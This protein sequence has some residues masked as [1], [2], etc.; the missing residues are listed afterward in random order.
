[1]LHVA[2]QPPHIAFVNQPWNVFQPP[3]Q[4]GSIAI[5]TDQVSRRLS[6]EYAV[7]VY[8]KNTPHQGA[9]LSAN[10]QIRY[11]FFSL[12]WDL[13]VHR[14]MKK[15]P[16]QR[17]G[18]LP[19][20]ASQSFFLFYALKVALDLRQ[21]KIDLVHI[22]NLSN[23]VPIIRRLNPEIKIVLHMHCE[24]L[25]Q[26]N[27]FHMEKRIRQCNL[28]LGCSQYIASLISLRFR[29]TRIPVK[30]IANGVAP[31]VFKPKAGAAR[32]KP[33]KPARVL[34]VGRISPEKGLHLLIEAFKRIAPRH[35]DL[36]LQIVGPH[37]PTPPQY[38]VNL[39]AETNVADLHSF[40]HGNYLTY[41]Q[42]NI[43]GMLASR[44]EFSGPIAYSQLPQCY[45]NA[46][47]LVNPSLSESFGMSLIEA[48]AC[49]CPVIASR[50]GGMPQIIQDKSCGLLVPPGDTASL[51]TA[52]D[53]LLT[54]H[55]ARQKMAIMARRR[56]KLR[57]G[58][59]EVH[60][61]L[62]R[63]YQSLITVK[64]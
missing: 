3:V 25:S 52:M 21:S 50:V 62:D 58:W 29:G 54:H 4:S 20:F 37:H 17:L 45:Q 23:F 31:T 33:I 24:W 57:F 63:L 18:G 44:I 30:S 60:R 56:A 8:A 15:L 59:D 55:Q 51:A 46:D 1:M 64:K 53:W 36:I 35:P 6:P 19:L 48:M 16:V 5:W 47:I 22:H 34:F 32:H 9:L 61:Q 14:G 28:L 11:R 10:H 39:S 49:G 2:R 13:Q 42:Q 12:R 7:T 43:P 41:L 38:L 40:Y 27:P 26:L